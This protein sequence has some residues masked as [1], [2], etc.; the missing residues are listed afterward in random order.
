MQQPHSRIPISLD[1]QRMGFHINL[2]IF[3]S[4]AEAGI[5]VA[6]TQKIRVS[7]GYKPKSVADL[8]IKPKRKSSSSFH[9]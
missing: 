8:R 9:L 6:Y 1:V 4:E 5:E 2:A 7:Y 3:L